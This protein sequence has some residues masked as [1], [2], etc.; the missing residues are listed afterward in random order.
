MRE[1]QDPGACSTI[2]GAKVAFLA[3]VWRRRLTQEARKE[4]H[5]LGSYRKEEPRPLPGPLQIHLGDLF[6]LMD[7]YR[8]CAGREKARSQHW[9]R[10]RGEKLPILARW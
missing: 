1:G 8:H 3:F 9:R 6:L 2:S 5:C 7:G 10:R 4:R